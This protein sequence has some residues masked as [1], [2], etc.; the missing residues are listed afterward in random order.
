M[1]NLM[2]NAAAWLGVRLQSAAGRDVTLV[3]SGTTLSITAWHAMHEYE[4]MDSDGLLTRVTSYDWTVAAEDVSSITLRP[5][6]TITDGALVYEAMGIGKRPCVEKLD[7]SGVLLL[8]H[9]KR[10]T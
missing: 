1:P 8:L 4:V 2:E 3:Q 5:G 7:S 6:A 9:T 10:V